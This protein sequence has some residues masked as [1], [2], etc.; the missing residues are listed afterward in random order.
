M[1]YFLFNAGKLVAV[2]A[3]CPFTGTPALKPFFHPAGKQ[4]IYDSVQDHHSLEWEGPAG[5]AFLKDLSVDLN[6]LTGSQWIVTSTRDLSRN[7][8][9]ETPKL[10]DKV[11]YGGNG[12]YYPCGKIVKITPS[13]R[14]VTDTG[15][16]F[17]RILRSGA[18]KHTNGFGH[19][20]AGHISQLSQEF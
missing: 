13:L 3:K 8:I 4:I 17:S 1:N 11:S 5:A 18:W 19:L 9:I 20:V 7:E 14:L 2:T 12:D 15:A 10:G 16:K 6:K